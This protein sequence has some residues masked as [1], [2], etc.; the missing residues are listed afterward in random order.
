M[1]TTTDRMTGAEF[2]A[3]R[4]MLGLTLD[5]LV[6]ALALLP[7]IGALPGIGGQ[8]AELVAL[9]VLAHF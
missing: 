1:T 5:E 4:H 2:A 9:H 3:R 8:D 7:E 6:H